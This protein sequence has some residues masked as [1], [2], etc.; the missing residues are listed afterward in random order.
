MDLT[1]GFLVVHSLLGSPY[2]WPTYEIA[3]C[4]GVYIYREIGDYGQQITRPCGVVGCIP[5]RGMQVVSGREQLQTPRYVSAH[6]ISASSGAACGIPG[7][8]TSE[9]V[10]SP[11]ILPFF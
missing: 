2:H 5:S 4:C 8:N 7:G 6:F 11:V 3:S 9:G 1:S 10:S